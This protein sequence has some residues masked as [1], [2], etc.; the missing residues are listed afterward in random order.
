MLGCWLQLL[1]MLMSPRPVA[2]ILSLPQDFILLQLSFPVEHSMSMAS[3]A[4]GALKQSPHP[5]ALRKKKKNPASAE[6]EDIFI[7]LLLKLHFF[8]CASPRSLRN[9]RRLGS[10]AS[11]AYPRYV[12]LAPRTGLATALQVS[13][14]ALPCSTG[15]NGS[16]LMR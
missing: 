6:R 3:G 5:D 11:W 15:V 13:Q 16:T 8:P 9:N 4:H 1:Q 14:Q 7:H 10:N 2:L 12:A